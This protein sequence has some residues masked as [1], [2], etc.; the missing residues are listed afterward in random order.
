MM[1]LAHLGFRVDTTTVRRGETDLERFQ[2]QSRRTAGEVD[3][4]EQVS[5]RAFGSV[6][7]FAAAAI[8]S[9]AGVG[10]AIS[11]IKDFGASISNLEAVA[12]P[13][14]EQ[15]AEM[16]DLAQELGSTT[17]F[18]ATE[19]AD[20]MTF[21]AMAGFE[22]SAVLA[23]IPDVLDL[24]AASG[25]G[26]AE[27]ADIL[28]NI[29]SGFRMEASQAAEVADILAAASSRSNTD[30][31]Q[32]GEAMKYAAPMAASLGFS[33]EET[34]AAAGVLSD[35]GMQAGMAGTRLVAIM[36]ALASP[37]K[38][39]RDTLDDLG[40]SLADVDPSVNSLTE[41]I[42]RLRV[43]NIKAA[44]A[45]VI[46]GREAAASVL[47]LTA[48]SDRL[49]D[50]SGQLENVA[51][52]ASAMAAIMSNNLSG[53]VTEF[54]SALQGLFLTIGDAGA[55]SAM[56]ALVQ[57]G[58]ALVGVLDT[59]VGST[60]IWAGAAVYLGLT[61]LPSLVAGLKSTAIALGSV[62]AMFI[63][64]AVASRAM[65]IAMR[66]IPILAVASA[67]GYMVGAIQDEIA[68]QEKLEKT[69]KTVT[70]ARNEMLA[71][72]ENYNNTG[73]RQARQTALDIA[74]G[75]LEASQA[76]VEFRHQQAVTA[77]DKATT[78]SARAGGQE[79]PVLE[80]EWDE[81]TRLYAEA[82][83]QKN[84]AEQA[85]LELRSVIL[86]DESQEAFREQQEAEK[87]ARS[88]SV[89]SSAA[90][91]AIPS[92]SELRAEFGYMAETMR[93]LMIAQNEMAVTDIR[94]SVDFALGDYSAFIDSLQLG[95]TLTAEIKS[96]IEEIGAQDSFGD[97]SKALLAMARTIE[98]SVGGL[99]AMDDETREV[100]EG[101]IDAALATTE[102]QSK[103]DSA[104]LSGE[105]LGE[106]IG[107]LAA[108]FDPAIEHAE[109]LHA[110]LTQ[111]LSQFSVLHQIAQNG[112][113][114]QTAAGMQGLFSSID[115]AP[116]SNGFAPVV[117][118]LR[119]A[120][121]IAVGG[122][123]S[124]DVQNFLDGQFP[125]NSD[126]GDSGGGG[127]TA[128]EE[129]MREY[130]AAADRVR[131]S[132]DALKS[133]QEVF[134]DALDQADRLLDAG[135]L[136]LDDYTAHVEQLERELLEAEFAPILEMFDSI[137]DAI[138]NAIVKGESLGDALSSVF[139]QI[140]ADLISS[141]ISTMLDNLLGQMNSLSGGG[142]SPFDFVF[143]LFGF[144][145]S[146]GGSKAGIPAKS[147]ASGSSVFSGQPYQKDEYGFEPFIPEVNGRILSVTEA[148]QA[149]AHGNGGKLGTLVVKADPGA[150]VDVAE[151]VADIK[152]IENNEHNDALLPAKIREY[153]GNPK[154]S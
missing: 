145:G 86:A 57:G 26:L 69:L 103:L 72:T 61:V 6:A 154:R 99:E 112:F 123:S 109:R 50:L 44:D 108:Q 3:R 147:K 22:A 98:L 85:L 11:V 14:N 131:A 39:A 89:L 125:Q 64:G 150:V 19:A 146:S 10:M 128:A 5:Q 88:Y 28:S 124:G 48:S 12:R 7:A 122:G 63:A 92:L 47:A 67:V 120:F 148:Q 70:D 71:A 16:R 34:A 40:V 117:D 74:E 137:A 45:S 56:R 36:A 55:E 75:Y 116:V 95:N 138:G 90:Y 20:A 25:M 42:E 1:D 54:N 51:G 15:L 4:L 129:Q 46:F 58:T 53:D 68:A 93:D 60:E 106:V 49:S 38:M 121:G 141:G 119:T 132:L 33:L 111:M 43:A 126:S 101:L 79:H 140:A 115:W 144:G 87:V 66:A 52:E 114:D 62:E 76:L 142:G 59:L 27:T 139:Q 151:R 153:A 97:Q 83:M 18:S 110:H 133:P 91:E 13:T 32:L 8:A 105:T 37:T 35:N 136:S 96:Q 100:W 30:V 107:K 135:V 73:T 94:A 24:A 9:M 143:S 2:K 84:E 80:Q 82:L 104:K 118:N 29:L 78:F 23:S 102:L 77:A 17:R 81:A 130:E 113:V 127:L 41:I 149:M 21:L 31:R 152:I 134:N 65:T